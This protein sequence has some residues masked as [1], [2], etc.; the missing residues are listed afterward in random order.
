MSAIIP[1]GKIK[2]MF[3][4]PPTRICPFLLVGS[5]EPRFC[6]KMREGLAEEML[7]LRL[8]ALTVVGTCVVAIAVGITETW[9]CVCHQ[10]ISPK[11]S[12][13]HTHLI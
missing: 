13:Q 12:I 3:Q 7:G 6:V 10:E 9:L 11:H 1:N 8:I 4:S 2:V 5:T